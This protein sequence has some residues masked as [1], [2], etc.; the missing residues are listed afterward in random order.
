[1]TARDRPRLWRTGLDSAVVPISV[2]TE[3]RPYRQFPERDLSGECLVYRAPTVAPFPGAFLHHP[4]FADRGFDVPRFDLLALGS[5]D[6]DRRSVREFLARFDRVEPDISVA[7]GRLKFG[8]V[9]G[10]VGF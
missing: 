1:M 10:D 6:V 8:G 5:G 4:Y 9:G 2:S 3:R 7:Q